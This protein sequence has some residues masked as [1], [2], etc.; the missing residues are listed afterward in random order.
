MLN[1]FTLFA[2]FV[3]KKDFVTFNYIFKIIDPSDFLKKI[4]DRKLISF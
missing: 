2:K 1:L 4:A 3:N